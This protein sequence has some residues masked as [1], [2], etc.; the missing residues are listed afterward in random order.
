MAR[1]ALNRTYLCAWNLRE[2]DEIIGLAKVAAK[3]GGLY[4]TH[5]RTK[6]KR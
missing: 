4:V 3:Y 2:D 5:M 6:A 1:S